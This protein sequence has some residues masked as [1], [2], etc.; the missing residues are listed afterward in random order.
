MARFER[1]GRPQLASHDERRYRQLAAISVGHL[2]IDDDAIRAPKGSWPLAKR[3]KWQPSR[4]QIAR[5]D[6]H[7]IQ[8]AVH[9]PMLEPIVEKENRRTE[10]SARKRRRHRP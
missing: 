2:A 5:R 6:D 10:R 7:E 3:A 8:I 9:R 1:L 4:T